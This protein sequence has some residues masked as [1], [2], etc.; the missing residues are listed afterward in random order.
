MLHCSTDLEAHRARTTPHERHVGRPVV[1]KRRPDFLPIPAAA[2]FRTALIVA[3]AAYASIAQ[4]HLFG[5]FFAYRLMAENVDASEETFVAR[6]LSRL[7]RIRLFAAE[8]ARAA[9]EVLDE[10]LG[11]G[12]VLALVLV[13]HLQSHPGTPH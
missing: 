10:P 8:S 2:F 7:L 5:D 12:W 9:A 6:C 1:E 3:A 11:T 4:E 13:L